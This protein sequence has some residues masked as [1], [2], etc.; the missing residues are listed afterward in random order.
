MPGVTRG[1]AWHR[2]ALGRVGA[3]NRAS[4]VDLG[5]R[6][7]V[8]ASESAWRIL[9]AEHARIREFLGSIQRAT[10]TDAWHKP[11][12]ELRALKRLLEDL[13]AFDD[14]THRPKG[15]ALIGALKSRSAEPGANE[16]VE[17][18]EHEQ[19]ECDRLLAEALALLDALA[20]G[21]ADAAEACAERLAQHR[22]LLRAHVAREDTSLRAAAF[23]ILTPDD[24]SAV[25][26]S[27]STLVRGS[28]QR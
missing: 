10:A 12:A 21:R 14:E 13:R 8:L 1:T 9:M 6:G 2:A 20:E 24:W 19:A 23:K 28:R 15:A 5:R 4:V 25:A 22:K 3:H 18:H 17:A 27:M 26:S 16:L 11:G 7:I